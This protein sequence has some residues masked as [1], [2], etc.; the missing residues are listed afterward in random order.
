MFQRMQGGSFE[1]RNT[2]EGHY[3]KMGFD[4]MIKPQRSILTQ[5]KDLRIADPFARNCPWA[6]HTNDIDPETRAESH[7]D[8]LLWLESLET[9]YFDY[10][11]FDP[12]FSKRQ[13]EEKYNGH[14]NVYTDP[15]YVAKC[16]QQIA[17]ILK[18]GGKVLKLGYNSNRDSHLLDLEKGWLICFGGNR[19]D[20]IMTLWVKGQARL[21]Y[22]QNERAGCE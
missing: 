3:Y 2:H 20:V 19:N 7:I 1:G 16:F 14:V 22:W 4:Y 6:S 11:L 10:V 9:E 5:I 17:R 12:P 13:A 18:N 15:G 8:A 21:T